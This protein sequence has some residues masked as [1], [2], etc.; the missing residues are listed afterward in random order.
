MGRSSQQ[1]GVE[2]L[3]H[4]WVGSKRSE[5]ASREHFGLVTR[6]SEHARMQES[7][8]QEPIGRMGKREEIAEPSIRLGPGHAG[9]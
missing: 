4:G 2:G 8:A 5:V 6:T 9:F 7:V 1:A 3:S